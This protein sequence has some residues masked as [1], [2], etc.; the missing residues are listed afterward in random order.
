LVARKGPKLIEHKVQ[1]YPGLA[2]N[3]F[4]WQDAVEK[5]DRLAAGRAEE[6]LIGEIKDAVHSLENVRTADLMQ[7]RIRVKAPKSH[8]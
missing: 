2:S 7:L 5:F 6:S 1:D 8:R 3:S 4:T